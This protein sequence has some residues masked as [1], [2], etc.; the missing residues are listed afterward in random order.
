MRSKR[1][2]ENARLLQIL[3]SAF[4]TRLCLEI[5]KCVCHQFIQ[6]FS[7]IRQ[8]TNNFWKVAVSFD[9]TAF[10]YINQRSLECLC[11]LASTSCNMRQ[12]HWFTIVLLGFF[13]FHWHKWYVL[14]FN[15]IFY[16]ILLYYICLLS[17]LMIAQCLMTSLV[18]KCCVNRR[19]LQHKYEVTTFKW[20]LV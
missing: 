12:T 10:L 19:K 5:W 2:R 11:A 4:I 7:L 20:S 17:V 3:L 8:R 16:F 1:E 9:G 18:L 13:V 15:I 6:R 14:S